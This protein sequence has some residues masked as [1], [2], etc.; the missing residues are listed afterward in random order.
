VRSLCFFVRW[1]MKPWRV[2]KSDLL[3][4]WIGHVK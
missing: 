3:Q 1:H 2:T 4:P